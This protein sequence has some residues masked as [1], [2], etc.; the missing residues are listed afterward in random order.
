MQF[1]VVR[2]TTATASAQVHRAKTAEPAFQMETVTSLAHVQ[3][4]SKE[5]SASKT[6]G[7]AHPTRVQ[8][9]PTAQ[10][11]TMITYVTA[12]L[13]FPER[14][15]TKDIIAIVHLARTEVRVEIRMMG[16]QSAS[17]F[18]A[19]RVPIVLKTWTNVRAPLA[20]T[21]ACV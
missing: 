7:P 1:Q 18:Q 11:W 6:P 15:V 14:I 16:R 21:E 5:T 10:I 9:T 19:T 17:V 12:E 4:E 2:A 8:T 13:A 3:R 20:R